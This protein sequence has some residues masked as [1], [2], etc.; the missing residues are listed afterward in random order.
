MS[1][2]VVITRP[3]DVRPACRLGRANNNNKPRTYIYLLGAYEKVIVERGKEEPRLYCIRLWNSRVSTVVVFVAR[4]HLHL[5]P[6]E[7]LRSM[8][9]RRRERDIHRLELSSRFINYYV[10]L[11]VVGEMFKLAHNACHTLYKYYI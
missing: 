5:A 9:R 6:S 8:R 4:V 1:H 11:V 2:C 7:K 10:I 3:F